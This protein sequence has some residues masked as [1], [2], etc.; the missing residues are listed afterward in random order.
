M[1]AECESVQGACAEAE[2]GAEEGKAG[3]HRLC[4]WSDSRQP[5]SR[6]VPRPVAAVR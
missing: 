5:S 1:H 2:G 4:V 6:A 3:A